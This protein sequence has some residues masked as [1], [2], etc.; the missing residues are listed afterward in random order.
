MTNELLVSAPLLAL[1]VLSHVGNKHCVQMHSSQSLVLNTVVCEIIQGL[2]SSI[3]ISNSSTND[4]KEEAAHKNHSFANQ[5]TLVV[6][7]FACNQLR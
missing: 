3:R 1:V 7:F 6:C 4:L 5:T 2:V